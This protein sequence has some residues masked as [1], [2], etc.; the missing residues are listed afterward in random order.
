MPKIVRAPALPT[1]KP[2][3]S[4]AA[5]LVKKKAKSKRALNCTFVLR[6]R[7]Y[8]D[9][10][11]SHCWIIKKED[12]KTEFSPLVE[13]WF[14]FGRRLTKEALLLSKLLESVI[15]VEIEEHSCYADN[16]VDEPF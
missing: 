6:I 3:N 9:S 16:Q 5:Q 11:Y 2:N 14:L 1:K 4:L 8:A 10:V 12:N 15:D 7:T 13:S